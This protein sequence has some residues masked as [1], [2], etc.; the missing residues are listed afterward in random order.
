M[1]RP[2]YT[3]GVIQAHALSGD[4]HYIVPAGY[5]FVARD[6][7]AWCD[8]G[9]S[10]GNIFAYYSDATVL[11]PITFDWFTVDVDTT[12]THH[13]EMRVA[14]APGQLVGVHADLPAD[15]SLTGY[16]LSLP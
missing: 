1:A 2:V 14:I 15:V 6:F 9:L 3:A 7:S 10:S 11:D 13:Q 5:L 12:V 8:A 16:L 4:A